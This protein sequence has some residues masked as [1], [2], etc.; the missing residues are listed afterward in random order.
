MRLTGA[1]QAGLRL[2]C[3]SWGRAWLATWRVGYVVV[4]VVGLGWGV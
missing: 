4:L 2:G 1:M 3:V